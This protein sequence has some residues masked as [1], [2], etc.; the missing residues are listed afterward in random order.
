[1]SET[2]LCRFIPLSLFLEVIPCFHLYLA[3]FLST[4]K[5]LG[6]KYIEFLM[7]LFVKSIIQPD[8]RLNEQIVSEKHGTQSIC[9]AIPYPGIYSFIMTWSGFAL[10]MPSLQRL[11]RKLSSQFGI[12]P[13]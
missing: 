8:P 6:S 5:L 9:F 13:K 7:S 10:K 12:L 2:R 3:S 4:N 11:L 1:M